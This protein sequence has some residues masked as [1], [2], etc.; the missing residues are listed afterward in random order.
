M[1][2]LAWLVPSLVLSGCSS[3][4]VAGGA[5]PGVTDGGSS[6]F[7][8]DIVVSMELTVKPGEELHQCQL[9]VLP[10]DADVNVVRIS[11]E[12]TAGSHHFLVFETDLDTIPADLEGQHDCVGGDE[13]IMQHTTGVLYAAQSPSGDAP[14]P[15]GVGFSLKAHQVLMLQTHYLNP[16]N[17][18]LDARV[19]AGFDTAPAETTPIQAGFLIFYDPF[20][21]LPA[22]SPAA[23]G[24][25]CTATSDI[26]ILAASTHYHQRGTGMQVWLDPPSPS[27]PTTAPFFE[28]H[29]WEHATNF[30]GPFAVAAGSVF[31]FQCD[32]FNTD[33]VEVFQGPNAATSEM[34]VF[35]G[36]YYPKADGAF[37]DCA[38]RSFL[39]YGTHTCSD[40]LSCIQTCPAGDAPHFTHGGVDVGPCWEKCVAMGCQ[41]ATDALLPL[42]SCIGNQCQAECAAGTCT[43]CALAKCSTEVTACIGHVCAP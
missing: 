16:S 4:S 35:A 39:G 7:H 32:Y 19:S 38:S 34:C 31:R 20:I 24:M 28:T 2:K 9:V 15:Q 12:Y 6:G 14:F 23:S 33:A 42:T 1:R 8:H 43:D 17:H 22:Q 25:R 40:Q 11:H 41:G 26:N 30:L 5:P 36:L 18:D 10:N 3:S 21:Y 27:T 13:P 29:D 37:D